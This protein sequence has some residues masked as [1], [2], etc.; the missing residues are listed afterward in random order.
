MLL[1]T[2]LHPAPCRENSI[3]AHAIGRCERGRTIVPH[4]CVDMVL[5]QALGSIE[6]QVFK[7]L[8][9][10]VS[11]KEQA[12]VERSSCTIGNR[13]VGYIF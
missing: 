4:M 11:S 8:F 1:K 6:S 13:R 9:G 3:V 5:V 7:L 2:C 12:V 10:L